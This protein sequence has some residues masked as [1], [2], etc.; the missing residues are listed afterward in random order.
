MTAS[1]QVC[2]EVGSEKVSTQRRVM[3][4]NGGLKALPYKKSLRE[5]G[6][7]SFEKR[8]M[9][10]DLI[11]THQYLKGGYEDDAD[12]V[13]TRSHML[14]I[15]G[16]ECRLIPRRFHLESRRKFFMRTVRH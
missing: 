7:F 13:F 8:R 12:S 1:E 11:N 2:S 6:L 3:R 10:D 9:R 4:I 16:N 5:Q 15:R 14:N